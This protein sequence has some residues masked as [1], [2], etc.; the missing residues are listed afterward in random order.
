MIR[1]ARG[2]TAVQ[3]AV[4]AWEPHTF[5]LLDQHL[6]PNSVF[7]DIGAWV[8]PLTLYACTKPGVRVVALEPDAIALRRLRENLQLNDA[9]LGTLA[10]VIVEDA[11]LAPND[12]SVTF[13]NPRG[14]L[15]R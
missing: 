1:S 7:V 3:M 14:T 13:G 11:C 8:G 6:R 12:G 10:R 5:V 2:F 4:G 15:V 9:A